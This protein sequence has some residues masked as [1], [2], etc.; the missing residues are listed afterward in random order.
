MAV[1]G[2]AYMFKRFIFEIW[3]HHK[4]TGIYFLTLLRTF[5]K[6][7]NPN[8]VRNFSRRKAFKFT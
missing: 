3:P 1:L 5:T 2:V 8:K 6:Q 7:P 4:F